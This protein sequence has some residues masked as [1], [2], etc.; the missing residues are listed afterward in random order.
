M[1]SDSYGGVI[2]VFS[3]RVLQLLLAIARGFGNELRRVLDKYLLFERLSRGALR[4]QRPARVAAQ[5]ARAL[6]AIINTAEFPS[7]RRRR[8]RNGLV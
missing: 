2:I 1:G 3:L 6:T 8:R 7:E 5:A 4:L